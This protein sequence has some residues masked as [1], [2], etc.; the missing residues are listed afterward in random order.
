MANRTGIDKSYSI[1]KR[2]WRVYAAVA[3]GAAGAVTLKKWVYP[4]LGAGANARTYQDA[5]SANALPS[6]N[7]YPLQYGAGAEGVRSVARTAAGLWTIKMQDAY[8]RVLS[9]YAQG[10]LAGGLSAIVGCGRNTSV[11]SMSANGGSE[12]GISLLSAT[13]VAA[14]PA[15]GETILLE[16]VLQDATEP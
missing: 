9:V 15:N 13:G 4:T 1:A 6:G 11:D 7:P 16:I 2:L 14:D 3:V 10:M 8:Q 5:A 12:F